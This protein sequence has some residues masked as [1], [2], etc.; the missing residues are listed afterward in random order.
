MH[1]NRI[2]GLSQSNNPPKETCRRAYGIDLN[3]LLFGKCVN[4][5]RK[6]LLKYL[7]KWVPNN[8]HTGF[9]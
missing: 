2:T 3:M 8:G 5:L 7:R 4:L 1:V 6:D 9:L